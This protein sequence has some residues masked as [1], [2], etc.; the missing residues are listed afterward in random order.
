MFPLLPS[1][2]VCF[3]LCL[4]SPV[5]F[6]TCLIHLYVFSCVKFIRMLRHVFRLRV[7]SDLSFQFTFYL[8][9]PVSFTHVF[10]L[11]SSSFLYLFTYL[12]HLYFFLYLVHLYIFSLFYFTCTF[13]VLI[14]CFCFF[15]PVSLCFLSCLV[16]LYI[17]SLV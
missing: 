12:V 7:F 5:W 9:C 1:S 10:S 13:L 11:L 3:L 8:L 17:A 14:F 4:V 2:P 15:P 16:Q 6:L